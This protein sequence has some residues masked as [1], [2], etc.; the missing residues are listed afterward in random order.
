MYFLRLQFVILTDR[1]DRCSIYECRKYLFQGMFGTKKVNKDRS[2]NS[3][4][5]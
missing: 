2:H 5:L 1:N 3:E 4:T